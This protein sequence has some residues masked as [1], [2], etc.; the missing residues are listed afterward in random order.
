MVELVKRAFSVEDGETVYY[1][2]LAAK[3]GDTKPTTGIVSGSKCIE[4]DTG[5]QYVFDGLS[6]TAAWTE[7]VVATATGE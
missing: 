1:V 2:E 6:T 5:K 3:S 7:V 4:V